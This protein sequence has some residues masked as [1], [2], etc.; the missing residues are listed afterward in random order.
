M[1]C[2]HVV[3]SIPQTKKQKTNKKTKKI[4]QIIRKQLR[5]KKKSS[6]TKP[7]I[8]EK[9]DNNAS[10]ATQECHEIVIDLADHVTNVKSTSEATTRYLGVKV[11]NDEFNKYFGNFLDGLFNLQ[12]DRCIAGAIL[13]LSKI[14][15]QLLSRKFSKKSE[16]IKRRIYALKL[17]TFFLKESGIK[18]FF[19]ENNSNNNNGALIILRRFFFTSFVYSAITPVPGVFKTMFELYELLWLQYRQFLKVESACKM[20]VCVCLFVFVSFFF[21][22]QKWI[23]W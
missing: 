7:E 5:N 4:P 20:F 2:F 13:V 15:S 23:C 18:S 6:P 21:C 1:F 10:Q 8:E 14:S 11:V 16:I 19:K 22:C 3:Y 9:V 17:L 12:F